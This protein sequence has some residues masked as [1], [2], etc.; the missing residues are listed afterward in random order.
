MC[1]LVCYV[2]WLLKLCTDVCI[3]VMCV[4]YKQPLEATPLLDALSCFVLLF[5]M[6]ISHAYGSNLESIV[7]LICT[8]QTSLFTERLVCSKPPV[9]STRGYTAS[10]KGVD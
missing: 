1:I 7:V 3:L 4:S 10:R 6:L 8:T 5:I 9:C 2:R